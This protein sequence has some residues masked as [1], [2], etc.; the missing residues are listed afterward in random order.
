MPEPTLVAVAPRQVARMVEL[1]RRHLGM[2]VA[3]IAALESDEQV[4]QV[5]DGDASMGMAVGTSTPLTSTYC[6]AVVRGDLPNLVPDSHADPVARGLGATQTFGVGS[7][8]GVPLTFA[9][10][11]LYGTFC[12]VSRGARPDLVERDVDFMTMLAALLVE[13]L[14]ARLAR[15]RSRERIERLIA[16]GS[17][18]VALQPIVELATGR[19]IGMEGLSR[20]PAG[21]GPPDVVFGAAHEVGLGADLEHLAV[22]SVLAMLPE[23]PEHLYLALNLAP[24]V[25]LALATTVADDPDVQ[26]HRLVL[27]ITEHAIVASYSELREVLQPLR[28]KGLR[29]AIDDAGAGYASLQHVIEMRPDIIKIDRSLIDGLARDP[30][31]RSVVSGFVLLAFELGATVLAEG[32]ETAEDLYAARRLGVTSAQGYV[33]DRPS[34]DPLDHKRWFVERDLLSFVA[35]PSAAAGA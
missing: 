23:L 32:V 19:C 12:C 10:G 7:Y 11:T 31:R 17:V 29:I 30:A 33:I 27:E 15:D 3:Y 2:D 21:F 6:A 16:A 35:P 5:V 14:E 25:A 28:D 1:A 4:M 20:F 26:W 24:A 34:V 8:I 9:D 18:D 22:R 13:E